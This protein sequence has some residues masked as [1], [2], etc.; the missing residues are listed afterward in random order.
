MKINNFKKFL[1]VFILSLFMNSNVNAGTIFGAPDCGVILDKDDKAT[2]QIVG[3]WVNG[4]MTAMNFAGSVNFG[5]NT[6]YDQRYYYI[7]KYCRENPL[8]SL[9]DA[10]ASLYFNSADK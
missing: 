8:K 4:F 2:K 9:N 7:V 3:S 5:K 6:S 1:G 10:A